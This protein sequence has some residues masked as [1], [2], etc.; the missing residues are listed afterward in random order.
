MFEMDRAHSLTVDTPW[1]KKSTSAVAR[2]SEEK[3]AKLEGG[4]RVPMSGGGRQKGDVKTATFLIEDKYTGADSYRIER[5]KL[6]KIS[7]EALREGRVPQLRL[8]FQSGKPET[9]RLI[10]ED[11]YL[12][13]NG[14]KNEND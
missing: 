13:M 7:R 11:D 12:E 4:R 3:A 1:K 14:G 6:R 9:W 5:G 8:T 10:R 2:K